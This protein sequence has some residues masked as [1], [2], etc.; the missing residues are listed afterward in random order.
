MVM[1]I[2]KFGIPMGTNCAA[3]VADVFLYSYKADF[4]QH[5]YLQKSKFK[6]QKTSFIITFRHIDDVLS[7]NNPKFNYYV[8][9]P[10]ELE[11]RHYRC[12]KMG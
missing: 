1:S 9:D 12:S 5:R 4:V 3:L 6:K 8:I 7:L 11:I 2:I 10:K